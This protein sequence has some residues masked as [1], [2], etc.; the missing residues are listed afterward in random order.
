MVATDK[1]RVYLDACCFIDLVQQQSGYKL[2]E[3]RD[4]HIW[5]CRKFLDA[6]RAKDIEIYGS[7]ILITECTKVRDENGQNKVL[8]D[9]VKNLFRAILL[10]GNPII[11][12][13][14]TPKILDR[15]R[16]L[17][18]IDGLNLGTVDAVHIATAITHNCNAF[19][20]TDKPV[21]KLKD[22]IA[23]LS[24]GVG[25]ADSF[26]SWLPDKYKQEP[27]ALKIKK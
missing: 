27:L 18:W 1:V 21:T 19:I 9:E 20:T 6:A 5:Y 22:Q 25:T 12:V 7:T 15:A 16:D 23:K 8:T 10:A 4:E 13:Q 2:E 3:G 11:P 26:K 24:I 17:S 14:P